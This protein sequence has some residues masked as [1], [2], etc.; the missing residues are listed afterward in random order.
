[1]QAMG[2]SKARA[3][4][5]CNLPDNFR[6]SQTDSAMEQFIRQKYEQRKYIAKEWIPPNITISPDV[7]YWSSPEMPVGILCSY[8]QLVLVHWW[9]KGK[10]EEKDHEQRQ[11]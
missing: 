7:S 9:R 4:Y 3:V 11:R 6:R 1:M 2:N 10:G 8:F 5:E